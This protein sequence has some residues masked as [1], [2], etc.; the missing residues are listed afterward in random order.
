M[1]SIFIGWYN[2]SSNGKIFCLNQGNVSQFLSDLYL[3]DSISGKQNKEEAFEFYLFCKSVLKE[4]S[5]NL[6]KWSTI[7][8][9]LQEGIDD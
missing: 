1:C 9:D 4:G 2:R 8:E 7:S 5:F 3:D 6:C